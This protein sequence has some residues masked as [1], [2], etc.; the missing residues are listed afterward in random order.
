MVVG[1]S[2]MSGYSPQPTSSPNRF[3]APAPPCHTPERRHHGEVPPLRPVFN[4]IGYKP[5]VSI[6]YE[7]GMAEGGGSF[8]ELAAG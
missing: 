3:A 2:G 5:G 8:W 4:H 6:R 7:E 1:Q